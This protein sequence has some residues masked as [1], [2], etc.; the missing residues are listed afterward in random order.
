[1][2]SNQNPHLTVG[3][4]FFLC[5]VIAVYSASGIFT[6][7]AS[8]YEFLSAHY[9]GCLFGAIFILGIY[10]VLWQVVLKKIPLNQAYLFRSLGLVYSL[11]IACFIFNEMISLQNIVGCGLVLGGL[12]IL[13]SGK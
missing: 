11:A 8:R 12:V 9:I 6:K 13:S 7:F 1:M 3:W 10:A 5:F 2:A 4:T